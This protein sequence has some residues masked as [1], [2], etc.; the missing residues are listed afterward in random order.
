MSDDTD[1]TGVRRLKKRNQPVPLSQDEVIGEIEALL[2]T[3]MNT[4]NVN[5]M[6]FK[7]ASRCEQ[8]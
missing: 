2:I 4:R 7:S 1:A 3:I 6:R 8:V 5:Q